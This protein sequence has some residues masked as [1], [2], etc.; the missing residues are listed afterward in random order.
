M[1]VGRPVNWE[2]EKVAFWSHAIKAGAPYSY[3]NADAMRLLGRWF[4]VLGLLCCLFLGRAA[5][6]DE[7]AGRLRVLSEEWPPLSYSVGGRPT[8]FA[9]EV[10]REMLRRAGRSEEIEIVPWARAYKLATGTPGVVLFSMARSPERE[11]LVTLIGPLL[12]VRTELYQRRGDRWAGNLDEA[13]RKA[14]VGTYRSTFAES[15]A[16][17]H[18]FLNFSLA[19]TPDRSARMLLAGRIDLWADSNLSAAAAMRQAGG[20]PAM[21]ERVLTLDVNSLMVAVSRGTPASVV[22]A[23]E[24]ALRE[25]KGD[26]TFQRIHHTWFPGEVPPAG[27]ESVGVMPR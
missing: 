27:V 1:R 3:G 24:M 2:F 6:A 19:T 9:V 22:D 14:L 4:V 12:D 13:R 21:L 25:M 26:G 16:R 15:S 7:P 17:Q 18:G 11:R 5:G 10:V 20:D 8:G 23:L